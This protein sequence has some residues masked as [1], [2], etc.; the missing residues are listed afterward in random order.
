MIIE[1]TNEAAKALAL[2]PENLLTLALVLPSPNT[3]S[4]LDMAVIDYESS[5]QVSAMQKGNRVKVFERQHRA[6]RYG[7]GES[8][9]TPEAVVL[10]AQ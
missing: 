2:C 8:D 9:H 1:T 7:N 5:Q 10:D 3:V 4:K 6:D